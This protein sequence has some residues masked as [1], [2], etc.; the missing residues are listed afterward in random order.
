ML[1]RMNIFTFHLSLPS[2]RG[3]FEAQEETRLEGKTERVISLNFAIL[4]GP[5]NTALET[6]GKKA[7]HMDER[8]VLPIQSQDSAQLCHHKGHGSHWPRNTLP[9]AAGEAEVVLKSCRGATLS[10]KATGQQKSLSTANQLPG[11]QGISRGL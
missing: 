8:I 4:G 7:S 1:G 3:I 5:G 6:F 9:G 10:S 2:Y 11:M